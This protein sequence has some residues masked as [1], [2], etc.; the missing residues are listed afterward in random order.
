MRLQEHDCTVEDRK[1]ISGDKYFWCWILMMVWKM[2]NLE[3]VARNIRFPIYL[4][5]EH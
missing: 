5:T 4:H 3:V 2:Q 1:K